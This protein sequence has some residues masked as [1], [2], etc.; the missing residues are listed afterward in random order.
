SGIS[1][2]VFTTIGRQM[3]L[4]KVARDP[5]SGY[6]RSGIV[7]TDNPASNTVVPTCNTRLAE[8]YSRCQLSRM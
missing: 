7:T 6:P 1:S 5:G 2:R 3:T 4:T 8:N